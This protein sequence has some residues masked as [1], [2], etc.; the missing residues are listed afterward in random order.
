[1]SIAFEGCG[2]GRGRPL[3]RLSGDEPRGSTDPRLDVDGDEGPGSGV[4]GRSSCSS[5]QF[6]LS[7]VG[8]VSAC[9]DAPAFRA[10][11]LSTRRSNSGDELARIWDERTGLNCSFRPNA[12]STIF[13]TVRFRRRLGTTGSS[14]SVSSRSIVEKT[15]EGGFLGLWGLCMEWGVRGFLEVN[16]TG[17]P[18]RGGRVE[19]VGVLPHWNYY[20]AQGI[21]GRFDPPWNGQGILV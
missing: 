11:R 10:A 15:L 14:A 6:I 13:G 8:R 3:F 1:V 16:A 5:S 21:Q 19:C 2:P 9:L 7:P 12:L 4:L 18:E 20:T 17:P